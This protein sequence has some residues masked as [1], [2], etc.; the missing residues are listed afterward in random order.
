MQDI[1]DIETS[2]LDWPMTPRKTLTM[3]VIGADKTIRTL[4]LAGKRLEGLQSFVRS[5]KA[6][7]ERSRKQFAARRRRYIETVGH[8]DRGAGGPLRKV[9]RLTRE[10]HKLRRQFRGAHG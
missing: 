8:R 9:A 2:G 4:Q 10:A 6:E 3:N 1:L 7:Q 5:V